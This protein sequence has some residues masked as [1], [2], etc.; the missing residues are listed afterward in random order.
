[1]LPVYGDRWFTFRLADHRIIPRFHL[2][3]LK[4]GQRAS[5][6]K[7]DPGIG[8]RLALLAMAITGEG[9]WVDQ[10]KP[11]VMGA[12]EAFTALPEGEGQ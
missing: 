9:G 1:M 8:E 4:S 10:A 11:I 2:E 3:G 6:F 12:G 5:I 7:T